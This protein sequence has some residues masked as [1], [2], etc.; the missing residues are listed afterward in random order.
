MK[1]MWALGAGVSRVYLEVQAATI[2]V[3]P[4]SI[5]GRED[6]I[7]PMISITYPF[8][9]YYL[10]K[11]LA[12]A[13]QK[14]GTLP[15]VYLWDMDKEEPEVAVWFGVE[16]PKKQLLQELGLAGN[17]SPTDPLAQALPCVEVFTFAEAN[18]LK[19]QTGKFMDLFKKTET[20]VVS[21]A[22]EQPENENVVFPDVQFF[23]ETVAHT[24]PL[25]N[26]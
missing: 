22:E 11:K 9:G 18:A 5:V 6:I 1:A 14:K 10:M 17:T 26:I 2:A 24:K 23:V 3:A 15:K 13:M 7:F 25:L 8:E 21:V 4:A 12:H 19:D 16:R 20:I